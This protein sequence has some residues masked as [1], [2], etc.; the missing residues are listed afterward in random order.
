LSTQ[1]PGAN[2]RPYLGPGYGGTNVGSVMFFDVDVSPT[3]SFGAEFSKGGTISGSQVERVSGGNNMLLNKHH[4][5]LVHG[6]I[7]LKPRTTTGAYAAVVGGVGLALRQ[8]ERTRTFASSVRPVPMTPA[9]QSLSDAVVAATGGVDG[10]FPI[11][12]RVG[13]LALARVH[14][15]I[16]EDRT[17]EGVVYRGVSSLIFRYGIGV[18]VGF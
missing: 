11:S 12:R 6:V 10:V 5:T 18:H 9:T 15:L 13:I 4:D 17:S 3:V 8:T 16:D 2:D 1:P 7:K 14:Y